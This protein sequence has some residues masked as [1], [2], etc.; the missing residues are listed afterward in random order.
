MK[1]HTGVVRAVQDA[2]IK[3]RFLEDG[4]EAEPSA[5]PE[6]FGGLIRS[7]LAKWAKVVKHAGIHPE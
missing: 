2:D 5:S 7:E 4:V 6:E 1:L 3:R